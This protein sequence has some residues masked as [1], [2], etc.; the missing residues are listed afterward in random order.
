MTKYEFEKILDSLRIA[1]AEGINKDK[2]TN[3]FPR[4]IFWEIFWD[5]LQASSKNYDTVVTYQISF[6][7]KTPRD[8]K[9][10]DLTKKLLDLGIVIQV[11]HEYIQNE[12]YFHSYFSLDL[13]E[14][15][16]L[17]NK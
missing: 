15:V 12:R 9:L 4:I 11:S 16:F 17:Q 1:V 8:Q 13:L 14:D 6:F 5:F 2:D 3:I 10:L 7:S